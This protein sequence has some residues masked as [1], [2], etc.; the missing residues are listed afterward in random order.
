[1]KKAETI[2]DDVDDDHIATDI[3]VKYPC[4][5]LKE[6]HGIEA[7]RMGAS[8]RNGIY[9]GIEEDCGTWQGLDGCGV[10]RTALPEPGGRS[11]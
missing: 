7:S 10:L 1:M 9:V 6:P 8:S 4:T 5:T 3:T 11:E 2:P